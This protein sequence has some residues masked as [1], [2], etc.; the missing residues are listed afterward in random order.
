MM[1]AVDSGYGLHHEQRRCER[2]PGVWCEPDLQVR[3]CL[4]QR[5]SVHDSEAAIALL[6]YLHRLMAT[7]RC[8]VMAGL[9]EPQL[10]YEEYKS[11]RPKTLNL[12]ELKRKPVFNALL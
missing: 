4:R 12:G 5:Q 1:E 6:C 8:D 11:K 10:L 9:R 7:R 3:D 2:A